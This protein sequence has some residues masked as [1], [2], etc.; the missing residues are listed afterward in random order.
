MPPLHGP[1]AMECCTRKPVNMSIMPLSSVTGKCTMISRDGERS[2]FHRPS[3][4]FSLRAAKSKRAFCASQGLISWS[5]VTLVVPV[6]ISLSPSPAASPA[7]DFRSR[8]QAPFL[9][10]MVGGRSVGCFAAVR[11]FCIRAERFGQS[12]RSPNLSESRLRRVCVKP[13]RTQTPN[14]V[15]SAGV[16]CSSAHLNR[17]ALAA[18]ASREQLH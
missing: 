9:Q 2:T 6:A 10:L 7:L 15:P 13:L 14:L 12:S 5:N 4:R 17:N 1:R 16:P 11:P 18:T 3:S 8:K